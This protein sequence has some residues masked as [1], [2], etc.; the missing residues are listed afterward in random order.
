MVKDLEQY[1]C[2]LERE[3]AAAL[4]ETRADLVEGR[5]FEESAE[6]HVKRLER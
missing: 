3:L 4:V 5:S 2:L 1:P 6:D